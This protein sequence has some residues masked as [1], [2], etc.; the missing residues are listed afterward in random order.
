MK[1]FA[2]AVSIFA[3]IVVLVMVGMFAVKSVVARSQAEDAKMR[4]I[5]QADTENG[6]A[7]AV[8]DDALNGEIVTIP[9]DEVITDT[10]TPPADDA[11]PAGPGMALPDTKDA[12]QT[13][14]YIYDQASEFL[15]QPQYGDA[16]TALLSS[17]TSGKVAIDAS[18]SDGL[19]KT[20]FSEF[21]GVQSYADLF[22]GCRVS[23]ALADKKAAVEFTSS[24]L[25]DTVAAYA[26]RTEQNGDESVKTEVTE[27]TVLSGLKKTIVTT[28]V[29]TTTSPDGM[30]VKSSVSSRTE[31]N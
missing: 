18:Q 25:G 19:A 16:V 22:K 27:V 5:M 20:F 7:G 28:T 10:F 23:F 15:A 8:S 9:D 12:A 3:G 11:I 6:A 13:A 1:Q 24:M 21:L 31:N 17:E 14:K 4:A 26:A 2:K 30:N 29:V